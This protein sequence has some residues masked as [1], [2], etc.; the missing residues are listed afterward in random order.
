MRRSP[1]TGADVVAT[2]RGH[3]GT[4][5]RHC[6]RIPGVGLDCAGLIILVGWQT[7]CLPH[8]FDFGGYGRQP[9]GAT[10]HAL[11]QG[12]LDRLPRP[13]DAT[14]GDIYLMRIRTLPQHLAI[15]TDRGI[16]HAHSSAGG[17][18]E[19]VLDPLWQ[20]R[21]LSAYRYKGVA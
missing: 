1:L 18:V 14:P 11:C 13:E 16:I 15:R 17:V 2:A 6:G 7:G 10:M 9:D 20:A 21:I 19:H 5:F 4:P 3:L 8:G 12:N